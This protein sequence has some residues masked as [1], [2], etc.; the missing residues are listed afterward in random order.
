MEL[1]GVKPVGIPYRAGYACGYA[2][3]KYY[4][5]KTKKSIYEATITPTKDI[6]KETEEFWN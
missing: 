1:R 6:L 4:L 5:K 2:L 3:I